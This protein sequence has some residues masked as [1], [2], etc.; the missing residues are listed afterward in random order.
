MNPTRIFS[1]RPRIMRALLEVF[2]PAATELDAAGLEGALIRSDE[3]V[4]DRDAALRRQLVLALSVLRMLA[5]LRHGR[6]LTFLERARRQAFLEKLQESRVLKLRLAVWGLRTLLFAGY[7]GD[8]ARQPELGYRPS[9]DG[10]DARNT[11][12]GHEAR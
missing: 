11:E 5:V 7:Y 6:G 8:P 4:A 12:A 9:P 2:V 3:L 1:A 10:W